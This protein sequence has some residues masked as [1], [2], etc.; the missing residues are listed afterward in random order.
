MRLL[1]LSQHEG[2]NFVEY[3]NN[4]ALMQ[5]SHSTEHLF[6]KVKSVLSEYYFYLRESKEILFFTDLPIL[7]TLVCLCSCY[8]Q[9]MDKL[10][11][12]LKKVELITKL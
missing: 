12:F 6:E 4:K 8:H 2:Q 1:S 9:I 10:K 7:R 11:A 3:T 5:I